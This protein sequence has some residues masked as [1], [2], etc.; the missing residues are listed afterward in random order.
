MGLIIALRQELLNNSNTISGWMECE[1]GINETIMKYN[2]YVLAGLFVVVLL[3]SALFAVFLKWQKV[4]CYEVMAESG[5]P[6]NRGMS[7]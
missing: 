6:T 1:P 7:I 5:L 2:E 4:W 3:L